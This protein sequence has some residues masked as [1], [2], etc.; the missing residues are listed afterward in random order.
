MPGS[1]FTP[2][3]PRRAPPSALPDWLA[4][5]ASVLALALYTLVALGLPLAVMTIT[6][7][8][9]LEADQIVGSLSPEAL[10]SLGVALIAALVTVI[11][12]FPV[13]MVTAPAWAPVR[14]GGIDHVGRLLLPTSPSVWRPSVSH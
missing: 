13:A 3:V 14:L 7:I 1:P 6:V 8:G 5:R 11:L 2:A 9:E 12:A 10:R 4:T